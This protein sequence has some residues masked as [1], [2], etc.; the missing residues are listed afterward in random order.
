M[1]LSYERFLKF[2]GDGKRGNRYA[3]LRT[4]DYARLNGQFKALALLGYKTDEHPGWK[5]CFFEKDRFEPVE[6]LGSIVDTHKSILL[7]V[8]VHFINELQGTPRRILLPKE[9]FFSKNL[10]RGRNDKLDLLIELQELAA[11]ICKF[12]DTIPNGDSLYLP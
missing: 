8:S 11:W 2:R 5:P 3:K 4:Q 1:L 7:G 9:T 12:W 6:K 10:A